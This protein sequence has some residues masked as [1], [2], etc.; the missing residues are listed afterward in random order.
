MKNRPFYVKNAAPG[1]LR[2]EAWPVWLFVLP[3]LGAIF[4][5]FI[6]PYGFALAA[7]FSSGGPSAG[8]GV[9]SALENPALPAVIR[10]TLRQALLSTFLALALGLPGAVLLSRGGPEW[11]RGPS[12]IIRSVTAI[13]FAMPPILVVLG[14]VLFF[15]NAGWANRFLAGLRSCILPGN[16]SGEDGPLRILYRPGAIILAHG[17][18]N[19]PLVIRL[20][21]DGLAGARK[22]YVPAAASLGASPLVSGLSILLPLTLPS[23]AAASLLVFLYSF[24]SFA[25]VLVLGGGPAATT[26]AVEIYRYARLS[27]D[28][29]NAGAL[30]LIETLIAGCAFGAYVFF[31]R[32]SRAAIPRDNPVL[33]GYGRG[34]PGP[35]RGISKGRKHPGFRGIPGLLYGLVFLFFILG[36]ILSIPV[37]SLLWKPSRAAPPQITLRWWLSLGDRVLPALCRSLLT[38]VLSASLACILAILAAGA[39]KNAGKYGGRGSPAAALIRLCAI[40]P[41]ASSGIVLSFGFTVLYGREYSRSLPAL[42]MLH[43]V[44]ALPF[45]FSSVSEGLAGI[46]QN[47]LNA[48]SS[49][50][51]GPGLRILTVELPMIFRRIRSA[52]GFAAAISLGELN[53]V[54]MLGMENWETLPLLIYRA[55]GS[56]RYGAACA[57]GS[58]LLIACLGAFLFSE[59]GI[60]R[61][62]RRK[63]G[64]ENPDLILGEKA[65][66]A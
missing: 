58:L 61:N 53:A 47:T 10:F 42:L 44:T 63:Q 57:A 45:A 56:Y 11:G 52:W 54:L 59:T 24:T 12:A 26:L 60:R 2:T 23:I 14:F 20:V 66:G 8:P 15:G 36:P 1:R 40:A 33:D 22:A 17:F 28:Y 43:A 21:G 32:Q 65:H 64:T 62:L 37:E 50:G 25:V 6:L 31:D 16:L 4:F 34:S 18:Y 39:V 48:A 35:K 3:P 27:L 7:G 51:A 41:L 9:L 49:C 55:A 46:P 38:A 19:F 13:P 5:C 30:A 29:Q